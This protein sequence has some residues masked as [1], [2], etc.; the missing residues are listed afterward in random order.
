M[1]KISPLA[2]RE[3][4]FSPPSPPPASHFCPPHLKDLLTALVLHTTWMHMSLY[5]VFSRSV[6]RGKTKDD[7]NLLQ[8]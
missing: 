7:R 5:T 2:W 3:G 1:S 4:E 8:R 6:V